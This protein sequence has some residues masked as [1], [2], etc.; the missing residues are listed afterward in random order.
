MLNAFPLDVWMKRATTEHYGKEF[1]PEIF[2]PYAGIAQQ[3]IYYY[4]RNAKKSLL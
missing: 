2:R 4:V 3:Y 1:D